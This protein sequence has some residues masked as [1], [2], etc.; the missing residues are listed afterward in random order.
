ML[1]SG[2]TFR[3]QGGCHI[4]HLASAGADNAATAE[5]GQLWLHRMH[6][7]HWLA[8]GLWVLALGSGQRGLALAAGCW[9]CCWPVPLAGCDSLLVAAR[10]AAEFE[11]YSLAIQLQPSTRSSIDKMASAKGKSCCRTCPALPQLSPPSRWHKSLEDFADRP[12]RLF[13][14]D[15]EPCANPGDLVDVQQ[16]VLERRSRSVGRRWA[17]LPWTRGWGSSDQG[18]RAG[19]I[20]HI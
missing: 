1:S 5:R 20:R 7:A 16:G 19:K 15:F 14:S 8:G 18:K 12:G 13:D 4:A 10:R 2:G 6:W 17:N 11:V 3:R 9:L